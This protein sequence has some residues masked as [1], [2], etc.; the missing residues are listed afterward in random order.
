MPSNGM[1]VWVRRLPWYDHP[2]RATWTNITGATVNVQT[3]SIADSPV[4]VLVPVA[5]IQT[6]KFQALADETNYQ[7]SRRPGDPR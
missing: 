1:A 4:N 3:V 5:A 7:N 2:V 6:W